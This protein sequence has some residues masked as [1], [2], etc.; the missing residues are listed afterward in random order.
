MTLNKLAGKLAFVT[1]VVLVAVACVPLWR[2]FYPVKDASG[3]DYLVYRSDAPNVSAQ[4]KDDRG[5]L[6]VTEAFRAGKGKILT[7]SPDGTCTP[8]IEG[9]NP[10][11]A[12]GRPEPYSAERFKCAWF[13]GVY[14]GRSMAYGRR[15]AHG[16][17]A[18]GQAG[19]GSHHSESSSFRPDLTAIT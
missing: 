10:H 9:R 13:H 16:P 11:M 18:A 19:K 12:T 15:H 14:Y 4:I 3:W 6:Y 7:L 17:A 2:H 8:Y 1:A 5:T